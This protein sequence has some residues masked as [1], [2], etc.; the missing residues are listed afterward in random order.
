SNTVSLWIN[1]SAS[2]FGS[3]AEP[4]GFLTATSGTDGFTIDR[5]NMLQNT[6]V[7][8]PAAI[9]W[10]ELRFG[11]SWA[12]VTPPP[13]ALLSTLK[14]LGNGAFQFA[15]TNNSAQSNN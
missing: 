14:K 2:T 3:S 6:A 8:V 1:P 10:D 4:G 9:Q 7:S 5:F 15:Y 13:P 11:T 12:V